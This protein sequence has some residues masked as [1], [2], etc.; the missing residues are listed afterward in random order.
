M[1]QVRGLVVLGCEVLVEG[2]AFM[3]HGT[4]VAGEAA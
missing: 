4:H 3:G 2:G 1:W